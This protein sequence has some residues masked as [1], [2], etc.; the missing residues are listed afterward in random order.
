MVVRMQIPS[1]RVARCRRAV[2]FT[3]MT[4]AQLLVLISIALY[5]GLLIML[6]RRLPLWLDEL[7][8]LMTASSPHF[9]DLINS[10]KGTPGAVPLGYITQALAIRM[11]GLSELSGR[12]PSAMASVLGCVGLYVLASR[13]GVRFPLIAMITFAICPLQLRY[14]LEAR[15]Y[16]MALALA[17]WSTVMFL[18][19]LS[20]TDYAWWFIPYGLCVLAGIYTQPFSFFVPFAHWVW[21]LFNA[22]SHFRKQLRIYLSLILVACAMLFFPWYAGVAGRWKASMEG[23]RVT[24]HI[25]AHTAL[26]VIRELTGSGYIGTALLLAGIGLAVLVYKHSSEELDCFLLFCFLIPLAC[27]LLMD[28]AFGYFGAIRQMI[29]ALAA[30]FVLFTIGLE[31]L[32]KT[33]RRGAVVLLISICIAQGWG[34]INFFFWRPRENWAQASAILADEVR[35][36]GCAMFSPAESKAYYSFFRPELDDSECGSARLVK[37]SRIA[38]AISPY[39][40]YDLVKVRKELFDRAFTLKS[41]FNPQGPRV[42]IYEL[43]H[44]SGLGSLPK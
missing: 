4:P 8:D 9:S 27:A 37:S 29:F 23:S 33:S 28:V 42:E 22:Q 15:S 24:S 5:C 6:L 26:L 32:L 35:N 12:L 34:D 19:I 30:A 44:K 16:E 10:V 25:T 17:I 11:L 36:G 18:H 31:R 1:E 2:P 43:N 39:D 38:L 41:E 13:I 21:L 7:I 20:Q 3:T 40:S 14:A